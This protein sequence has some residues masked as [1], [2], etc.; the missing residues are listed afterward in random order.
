MKKRM[1]LKGIAVF[2]AASMLTGCS[3]LSAEDYYDELQDALEDGAD[4]MNELVSL[5]YEDEDDFDNGEAKELL[6]EAKAAFSSIKSLSAPKEIKDEHKELCKI[7]DYTLMAADLE[8]DL[9]VATV[10]DNDKKIEKIEEKQDDLQDEMNDKCDTDV[11]YEIIEELQEL[12][13]EEDD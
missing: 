11:V 3:A 13:E 9:V 10:K 5:K 2:L 12:I 7:I 8:Y 4:A 6:N 1:V